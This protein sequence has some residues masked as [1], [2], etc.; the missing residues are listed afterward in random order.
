ML[1]PT[2]RRATV[3]ERLARLWPPEA[4]RQEELLRAAIKRLVDKPDEPCIVC[5]ALVPSGRGSSENMQRRIFGC[6][7]F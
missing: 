7:L 4:R 1:V 5:G 2:F 3:F 6:E